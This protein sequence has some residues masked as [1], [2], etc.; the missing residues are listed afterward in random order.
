MA[1][2]HVS[3]ICFGSL[4]GRLKCGRTTFWQQGL[5]VNNNFPVQY[6]SAFPWGAD[7][8]RW[9]RD[10]VRPREEVPLHS[11]VYTSVVGVGQLSR[12]TTCCWWDCTSVPPVVGLAC[13]VRRQ[14]CQAYRYCPRDYCTS[15]MGVMLV[16]VAVLTETVREVSLGDCT[17][18]VA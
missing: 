5:L 12:W 18:S 4:S 7:L 13:V 9:H 16:L 1:A 2:G 17:S 6:W 8:L 15:R 11:L 10:E 3:I 14:V